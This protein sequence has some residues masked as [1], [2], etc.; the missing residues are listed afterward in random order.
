MVNNVLL[1]VEL[2]DRSTTGIELN[3]PGFRIGSFP[4]RY[5]SRQ[6]LSS[7]LSEWEQV[8]GTAA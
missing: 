3:R 6:Q 8:T 4:V 1:A 7:Q 5:T 2:A